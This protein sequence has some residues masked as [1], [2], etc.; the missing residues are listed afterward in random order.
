MSTSCWNDYRESRGKNQLPEDAALIFDFFP[1]PEY[2]STRME[3][4]G[5]WMPRIDLARAE[6]ME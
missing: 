1:F 4:I 2:N 6:G 5:T 3:D